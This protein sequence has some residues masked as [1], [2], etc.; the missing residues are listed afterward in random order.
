MLVWPFLHSKA[1]ASARTFMMCQL[2]CLLYLR[3]FDAIYKC[4]ELQLLREI[5]ITV[6]YTSITKHLNFLKALFAD[7]GI[8]IASDH[9]IACPAALSEE[10]SSPVSHPELF[11]GHTMPLH[12][13]RSHQNC[14]LFK[15]FRFISLGC[16]FELLAIK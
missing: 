9:Y 15:I 3:V 6:G 1:S 14:P 16:S 12:V 13:M 11:V 8:S 10:G 5:L 2:K 4:L 7:N